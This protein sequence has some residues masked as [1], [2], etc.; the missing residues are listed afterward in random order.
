MVGVS[1]IANHEL[2]ALY[3]KIEELE[4]ERD[5]L[6]E[7]LESARRELAQLKQKNTDSYEPVFKFFRDE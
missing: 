6:R 5:V 3:K 7:E 4:R 1:F 2:Q